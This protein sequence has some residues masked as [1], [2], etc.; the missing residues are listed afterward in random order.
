MRK[1]HLQDIQ[2]TVML[3]N[4]SKSPLNR[5]ST[6]PKENNLRKP[7]SNKVTLNLIGMLENRKSDVENLW[8]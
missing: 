4:K 6:I 1:H 7:P 8:Q 3:K 5:Q 2:N